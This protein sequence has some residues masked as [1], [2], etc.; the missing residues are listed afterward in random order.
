MDIIV[1]DGT[2]QNKVMTT[3]KDKRGTLK[4]AKPEKS[5][6]RYASQSRV[7]TNIS[8]LEEVENYC[9]IT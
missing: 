9:A 5:L 4:I 7:K 8:L 2:V 6:E 3:K 1:K